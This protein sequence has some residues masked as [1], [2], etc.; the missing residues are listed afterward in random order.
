MATTE[1]ALFDDIADVV[2]AAGYVRAQGDDFALQPIGAIDGA[3]T[4]AFVPNAPIGGMNFSEVGRVIADI[5]VARSVNEDSHAARKTLLADIRAL[6]NAIVIDGAQVSGEY[7]V[8][9]G[10]RTAEI[11]APPGA[12]Y[13]VGRVRLP[14]NF[15]AEI[16]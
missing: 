6:I 15:E 5:G 3:F 1:D 10:G 2:V 7:A 12:S 16:A 14:I 13:L 4:L 11:T 8:E 9:D